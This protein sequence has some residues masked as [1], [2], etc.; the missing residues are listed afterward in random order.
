M[1]PNKLDVTKLDKQAAELGYKYRRGIQRG[2]GY[3]VIDEISGETVLGGDDFTATL[4]SVK[5]YFDGIGRELKVKA[6]ALGYSFAQDSEDIDAYV[7][8]EDSTGDTLLVSETLKDIRAFIDSAASDLDVEIEITKLPKIEPPSR[9][10]INEALCGHEHADEIRAM[11]KSAKVADPSGQTWQD[12]Q[13]EVRALK[14]RE[15]FKPN[16]HN[17]DGL[18]DRNEHDEEDDRDLR[19]YLK[20]VE[21]QDKNFLAPDKDEPAYD[22]PKAPA[23]AA[24][25]S[26][27]RRFNPKKLLAESQAKAAA[28]EAELEAELK[29]ARARVRAKNKA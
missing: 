22:T 10:D 4:K 14:S 1:N 15:E 28:Q 18:H 21:R 9:K 3:I 12:L 16:W 24:V 26:I 5:E 27:T 20:D 25:V 8:T 13:F 11:Q 6:K 7:L 29:K 17:P 23:V 2:A 19:E